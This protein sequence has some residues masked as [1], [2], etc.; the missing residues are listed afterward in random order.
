MG[1]TPCFHAGGVGST[2]GVGTK[3]PSAMWHG[4]KQ[5]KNRNN[6]KDGASIHP[7]FIQGSSNISYS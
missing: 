6:V 2:P 5:T 4:Q 3:I 1:K 7:C